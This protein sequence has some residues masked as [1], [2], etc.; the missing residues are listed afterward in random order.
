MLIYTFSY[1]TE[2]KTSNKSQEQEYGQQAYNQKTD[3]GK[4]ICMCH[5]WIY[6][7]DLIHKYIKI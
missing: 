4:D 1:T 5:K 2:T 6:V 3:Q 7:T